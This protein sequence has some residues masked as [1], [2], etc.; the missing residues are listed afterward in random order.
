MGG[1]E[2]RMNR[3]LDK[4]WTQI[5]GSAVVTGVVAALVSAAALAA[6]AKME[7]KGALQPIN[8]TSHWLNGDAAAKVELPTARHTGVGFVTHLLSAIFW[9][10][11][12]EAWLAINP[13]RSFNELLRDSAGMAGIAAVVDYGATPKRFTPGWELAV[14]KGAMFVAYLAFALGLA[15]GAMASE[16]LVRPARGLW[17]GTAPLRL[18]RL[19]D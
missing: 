12:F 7:G 2:A 16:S 17:R 4:Q 5:G 15:G 3:S 14:S 19:R 9:A 8:A 18:S 1:E 10:A 6:V 13:P 11:P